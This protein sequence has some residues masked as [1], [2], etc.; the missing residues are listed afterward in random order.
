MSK[1]TGTRR[2]K[3]ATKVCCF[4]CVKSEKRFIF[5]TLIYDSIK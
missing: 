3:K 1:V 4:L 2:N 5:I